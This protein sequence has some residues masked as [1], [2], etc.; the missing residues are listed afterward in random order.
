MDKMRAARLVEPRKMVCED[1]PL[2]EPEAGQVVVKKA[3][4]D[5]GA[6]S[7]YKRPFYEAAVEMIHVLGG[8]PAGKRPDSGR[9]PRALPKASSV[10]RSSPNR[11]RPY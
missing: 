7:S 3:Y 5:W 4:A 2:F 6:W 9:G 1:T 10:F 11:A 8:R